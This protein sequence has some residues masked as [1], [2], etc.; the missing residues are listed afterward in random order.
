MNIISRLD[1]H[2]AYGQSRPK[3]APAFR[4][5]YCD[6]DKKVLRF[7]AYFVDESVAGA[8][9]ALSGLGAGEPEENAGRR[10][11]RHV[12][13][14]YH[15]EDDTVSIIEPRVKNSGLCQGLLLKRHRIPK[16]EPIMGERAYWHWTDLS[17]GQAVT[18]YGRE[19][20]IHSCDDFTRSHLT[21]EGVDQAASKFKAEIREPNSSSSLMRKIRVAE[22]REK[23]PLK[24]YLE[25]D[26]QVLR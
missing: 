12:H 5:R 13:L 22:K 14:H 24:K 16:F 19:Y 26:G 17:V 20:H 7:F 1:R 9:T 23:A 6:L 10:I 21:A 8:D 25:K 2:H 11:L 4:P 18:F 3:S 15:L